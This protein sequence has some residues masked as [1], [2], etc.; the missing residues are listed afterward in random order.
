MEMKK[1]NVSDGDEKWNI[2]DV[3]KGEN[4]MKSESGFFWIN[5]IK[6]EGGKLSQQKPIALPFYCKEGDEKQKVC[7]TDEK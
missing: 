1:W 3:M 7:G 6:S 2:F 4:V 5:A